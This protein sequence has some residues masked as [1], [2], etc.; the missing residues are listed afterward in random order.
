MSLQREISFETEVCDYLGADGWL[1]ETGSAAQYD[2]A[3]AL[4]VRPM[5]RDWEVFV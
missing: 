2:R 4:F 5:R 3:R 1:Y